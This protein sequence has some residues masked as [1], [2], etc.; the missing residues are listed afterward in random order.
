MNQKNTDRI[1]CKKHLKCSIIFFFIICYRKKICYHGR[2]SDVKKSSTKT[3]DRTGNQTG[4]K[5]GLQMNFTAEEDKIYSQNQKYCSHDFRQNIF[6]QSHQRVHTQK[7]GYCS[8]DHR[9]QKEFPVNKLPQ[10]YSNVNY[11]KESCNGFQYGGC[12]KRHEHGPYSHTD[13]RI[14]ESTA[15]LY[16]TSRK[17]HQCSQYIH[18]IY[19]PFLIKVPYDSVLPFH[20]DLPSLPEEPFHKSQILR[21]EYQSLLLPPFQLQP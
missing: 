12:I 6:I 9:R 2:T 14:T 5:A 7:T 11:H 15:A 20:P 4:N 16:K 10:P 3:T 21:S 13:D 8:H 1:D 18:F 19:I 17:G